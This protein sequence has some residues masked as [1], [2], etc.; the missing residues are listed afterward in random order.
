ML[1]ETIRF[2]IKI[3]KLFEGNSTVKRKNKAVEI[4]IGIK[5]YLLKEILRKILRKYLTSPTTDPS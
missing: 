2:K 4:R 3:T 1:I 5:E